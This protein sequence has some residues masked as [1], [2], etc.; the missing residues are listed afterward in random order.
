M[1]SASRQPPSI[2]TRAGK[3]LWGDNR[4]RGFGILRDLAGT[5]TY[6]SLVSL[7]LGG[8]RL[9][10]EDSRILDDICVSGLAADPRIW[11]LKISRIVASHGA[12]IS[13]FCAAYLALE[14]AI[15]GPWNSG[16]AASF[17]ADLKRDLNGRSEDDAA[18]GKAV[19][20]LLAD[21][22]RLRGFGVPFRHEDERVNALAR[23]LERRGRIDE[24]HW[25][26]MR[27][28]ENASVEMKGLHVNIAGATAAALL[29][30]GF[31]PKQ[32][33]GLTM[34]MSSSAVLVNVSEET[35]SP[36]AVL[37]KLPDDYIEYVGEPPRISPRAIEKDRQ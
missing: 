12:S 17:L 15:I 8:R 7:A 11:P 22:K 32:I 19:R 20:K 31:A 33:S 26:L 34:A 6:W 28:V 1:T 36:N 18:I 16:H 30:M 13:A 27:A 4:L 10:E 3:S 35:E 14:D 23:C 37:R 24:P 2:V 29:D 25:R 5:D 21:G 9:S